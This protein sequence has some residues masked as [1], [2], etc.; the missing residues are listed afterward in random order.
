ML[1]KG[2]RLTSS[3]VQTVLSRGI[4]ISISPQ[5]GRNNLISARFLATPGGFRVAAVAP[6]SVAK[7]AVVRN[8]LRRAVYRAVAGLPTPKKSGAVVFFVRSIPKE[9]LTPAF[10]GEISIF[11]EKISAQ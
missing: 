3:D 4:S 10:A 9:A 6:K 7:S 5:K 8:R 2:K 11:L 1:P